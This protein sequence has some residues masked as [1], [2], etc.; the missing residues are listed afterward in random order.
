MNRVALPLCVAVA[1]LLLP[2]CIMACSREVVR[3]RSSETSVSNDPSAAQLVSQGDA[4]M[5]A[6][7]PKAA[8]GHYTQAVQADPGL[9]GD[10]KFQ[11]RVARA[12]AL[13]AYVRGRGEADR[14]EWESAFLLLSESRS[15]DPEFR[16][17]SELLALARK[18]A[19]AAHFNK[20][21]RLLNDAEGEKIKPEAVAL[22]VIAELRAALSYDPDLAEARVMID[23]M[24]R[25]TPLPS[26]PPAPPE[27]PGAFSPPDGPA[28]P[29]EIVPLH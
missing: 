23:R 26:A 20:A 17:A 5:V 1:A 6:E 15:Y 18:Q 7:D 27:A 28:I 25:R 14:G 22:A 3:E 4:A 21:A 29:P 12:K 9:G 13:D 8:L 24:A 10:E 11:K 16:P 19:A 2:G